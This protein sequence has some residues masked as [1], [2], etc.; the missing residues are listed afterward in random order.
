MD[1]FARGGFY[2]ILDLRAPARGYWDALPARDRESDA[3]ADPCGP[4]GAWPDARDRARALLAAGPCCL[5]IRAKDAPARLVFE[6]ARALRPLCVAARVPLCI[7]D[8]LDVAI[9]AGAELAHLGQDD[10]PLAEARAAR[11]AAGRTAA[12]LRLGVST[13]SL[14]QARAAVAGGADLIGFGPVFPT[15]SKERP[16][17]VV[18]LA[19]LA[20]V[21]RAVDV[22]VVAIGGITPDNVAAVAATGAHAAAVIAAVETASDPIGVGLAIARAFARR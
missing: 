10:L 20:E 7:N 21:V 17:P 16:D 9:L 13:H 12:E 8:R 3:V 2:A 11:A 4:A 5:Q 19:A 14:A 22:P 18:G 6:A 15:G 1:A